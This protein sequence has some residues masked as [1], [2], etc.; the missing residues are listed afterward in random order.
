MASSAT[1]LRRV[2]VAGSP[3]ELTLS[4]MAPSAAVRSSPAAAKPGSVAW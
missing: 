2:P 1:R 4:R 3:G